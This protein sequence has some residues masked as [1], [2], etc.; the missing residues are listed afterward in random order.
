MGVERGVA[1]GMGDL[2]CRV[3]P[4]DPEIL[5]VL[6]QLA[7]WLGVRRLDAVPGDA[8]PHLHYGPGQAAPSAAR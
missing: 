4:S 5:W 8:R 2:R 1:A 7:E 6:D 3:E